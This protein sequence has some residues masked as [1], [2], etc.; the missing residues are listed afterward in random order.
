MKNTTRFYNA[1]RNQPAQWL[2]WLRRHGMIILLIITGIGLQ[3]TVHAQYY[4][5]NTSCTSAY[6]DI[7]DDANLVTLDGSGLGTTTIP[8]TFSFYGIS[9]G[10]APLRISNDGY[11][12]F[13]KTTGDI[14]GDNTSLPSVDPDVNP[15]G[16]LFPWW[17][18]VSESVVYA[19]VTGTA[20]NREYIITW[21]S[22]I[23]ENTI[24]Y[25]V[26]FKETTNEICF[27]YGDKLY[28]D[29]LYADD[30]AGVS[31][32]GMQ[33]GSTVYSESFNNQSLLQGTS[34]V[35]FSPTAVPQGCTLG[36][37]SSNIS[38][39]NYCTANL[40]AAELISK[41]GSC[42]TD[43]EITL[44]ETMNGRILEKGINSII[45]DGLVLNTN[46]AYPLRN[47]TYV[48][49]IKEMGVPFPNTCWNWHTFEDKAPPIFECPP[50]DTIDCYQLP[51]FPDI[52]GIVDCSGDVEMIELENSTEYF[53]NC[54]D[55]RALLYRGRVFRSFYLVD[56]AGNRSD[57][58]TQ[59]IW[60]RLPDTADING[61]TPLVNLYCNSTFALDGAGN[62]DPSVTGIPSIGVDSVSLY[63]STLEL[64][65]NMTSSYTDNRIQIGC[66]TKIFRT[67]NIYTWSCTGEKQVVI[68]QTIMILDTLPPS[69]DPLPDVTITTSNGLCEAVYTVPA[70]NVV[71]ECGHTGSIDVKYPGGHRVQNGG[72]NITLPIGIHEIV[73]I[74]SDGCG[75]II[76]DT[77]KVTVRDNAA[78]IA[79]CKDAI[80]GLNNNGFARMN[81][82][83]INNG[84]HDNGC[85]PVTVT[86]RRM[87]ADCNGDGNPQTAPADYID[88]YC[89]DLTAS[90]IM[91]VLEVTDAGG[92]VNT[93]MA[94]VTVQNK[95][96]PQIVADL[97]ALTVPCGYAYD[98]D[99]LDVSFGRYASDEASR[100]TLTVNGYTFRDGLVLG[101][102]ALTITE[103]PAE[104]HISNCGFGYI[105]RTFRFTDGVNTFTRT[106]R[107]DFVSTGAILTEDDYYRPR[108]TTIVNGMCNV[109]EIFNYDFGGVYRPRLKNSVTSC[110]NLMMN[111]V[112][113][114]YQNTPGLC[115]KILRKWSII[116]WCL[117]EA[118]DNEYMLQHK[119]TF[120]QVIMIQNT[121]PPA[122]VQHADLNETTTNCD[123]KQINVTT[124]ATDECGT[125]FYTYQVDFNYN[126]A[127]SSWDLNGTGN[128]ANI[129]WPLG[130]HLIRFTARD[131]CG[132]SSVQNIR[133]SVRNNKPPT[134]TLH[135]LV[136]ELMSNYMI[137]IPARF[138]DSGSK[139]GC[140]ANGPIYFAY[141]NNPA[142]S[143]R[144]FN[145][146]DI[147][148]QAFP[149]A[150]YVIDKNGNWD[151]ATTMIEVQDNLFPCPGGT[152]PSIAG[153]IFTDSDQGIPEVT[154]NAGG[155]MSNTTD[156]LGTYKLNNVQKNKTYEIA[157]INEK[158]PLNGVNTGDI[159][160]IQ[161]HILGKTLIS[162]PYRQIAA[163]VNED[164]DIT[165]QDIVMIRK[166]LL[167]KIDQFASGKSWKFIDKKYQFN[168]PSLGYK[169]SYPESIQASTDGKLTDV[170]F[171]GTKL[172]DVDGTVKVGFTG[173]DGLDN[174][175]NGIIMST[176]DQHIAAG[177]IFE[178]SFV[179]S[180]G[181]KMGGLQLSWQINQDIEILDI[182]SN[183]F[184]IDA[185]NYTIE[186]GHLL[187]S[188][189][190][191][192]GAAAENEIITFRCRASADT[193]LS[194]MFDITNGRLHTEAY[195][196]LG[197]AES[198]DFK[199]NTNESGIFNVEQNRPNPFSDQTSI[200]FITDTKGSVSL[201]VY[202]LSG[203]LMYQ[204]SGNFEA[205]MH[206]F[207]IDG[208][209][210][211]GTGVYFYEIANDTNRIVKRMVKI[212]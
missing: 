22:G 193:Y 138:F 4:I 208:K 128:A 186:N 179:K 10:A 42:A 185:N 69:I 19:A 126:P 106:Q 134:V 8:F 58:C 13:N 198:L 191:N 41:G 6:V 117:A 104:I 103:L 92:L 29:G 61:V 9:Y 205:G 109:D 158:E 17:N 68:P 139:A 172:G 135:R 98:V 31:T 26:A 12:L 47:K 70:I 82:S 136:T 154:V 168:N 116:D 145:C 211:E 150:I 79:I 152:V 90:P 95:S 194:D 182:S 53:D 110:H 165:A 197:S 207:D 125:V 166:L 124:N 74:V 170:D 156:N 113:E 148:D 118:E 189:I 50:V 142:D 40:V 60:L 2:N 66:L 210:I 11:V 133:I 86:I 178:V 130:N 162:N 52:D 51:I 137:T 99:H 203:K 77:V 7:V 72:F 54:A 81:S 64:V 37:F 56:G 195:D 100:R 177:E 121:I 94:S 38:L 212:Q 67:W 206:Q 105:L 93:C 187:L 39:D 181:I 28:F 85:G 27:R 5:P 112:D 59:E 107:I 140:P 65:C 108:D 75:N 43:Y 80:V 120:V 200:S 159:I 169:E 127:V 147:I 73:Y 55:P 209:A 57:T 23:D 16:A 132:N 184:E 96:Q 83:A 115:Y 122:F 84:S 143:L 160:K 71:D 15:D 20:P 190:A 173:N 153:L 204:T 174:R 88:F 35:L 129:Y 36:C 149:I 46:T 119:I 21:L 44:R 30:Y 91:V 45:A 164:R 48:I 63:P 201:K 171:I 183:I 131:G 18:D 97:P 157:P 101:V 89:C 62:P 33:K 146:D 114:V 180:S 176:K 161:N 196:Q 76:R 3:D 167:N 49:E 151:F 78:P 192:P 202:N 123:G 87:N 14:S 102:C 32:I 155:G 111:Y 163:D 199:F 144:T 188:A 25:Q 34:C 24:S 175:S 1:G 141:S